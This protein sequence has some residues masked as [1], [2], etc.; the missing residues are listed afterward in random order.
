MAERGKI[1]TPHLQLESETEPPRRPPSWWQEWFCRPGWA[2][3]AGSELSWQPT[4]TGLKL[5][6][7]P[8][9]GTQRS[10]DFLVMPQMWLSWR[11][12][13]L[14]GE[15][16]NWFRPRDALLDEPPW[17]HAPAQQHLTY[18]PPS[19]DEL[20]VARWDGPE[21]GQHSWTEPHPTRTRITASTG[22]TPDDF[23]ARAIQLRRVANLHRVLQRVTKNKTYNV[24][25]GGPALQTWRV[26]PQRLTRLGL[27]DEWLAGTWIRNPWL[28]L[29]SVVP[30]SF[31][32]RGLLPLGMWC[33]RVERARGRYLTSNAT[34]VKVIG[35]YDIGFSLTIRLTERG[36]WP[37]STEL[38]GGQG[39]V[40][41]PAWS[42][43]AFVEMLL[44]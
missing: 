28:D 19:W 4:P 37:I 15:L 39:R 10:Y 43:A 12:S 17:K 26:G 41:R 33:F 35:P 30:G 44:R 20:E 14:S 2:H 1:A 13:D 29:R 32:R 27:P 31:L 21:V 18:L 42:L 23:E 11:P 22:L 40:V 9:P 6:N 34:V 16:P 24:R 36:P 38:D 25:L 3:W 5:R 8:W 7:I